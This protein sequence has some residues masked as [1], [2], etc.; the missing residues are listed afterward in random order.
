MLTNT[1]AETS[2]AES[3]LT[4][5]Q[6][7]T[8]EEFMRLARVGRSTAY[9]SIAEGTVKSIRIGRLIRIPARQFAL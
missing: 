4:S 6:L 8:V 7:L 5:E 2:V 9:K 1:T 3:L